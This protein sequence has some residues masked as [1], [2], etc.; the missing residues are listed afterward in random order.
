MNT[1]G[2]DSIYRLL[3]DLKRGLLKGWKLKV[4]TD[5]PDLLT[6]KIQNPKWYNLPT[7]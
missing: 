6:F 2:F 4:C 7:Y 5:N 3:Q 1:D